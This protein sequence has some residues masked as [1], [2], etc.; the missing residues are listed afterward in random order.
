[1][2]VGRRYN[3]AGVKERHCKKCGNGL[4]AITKKANPVYAKKPS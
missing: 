1:V 2:R 4:G 3:D